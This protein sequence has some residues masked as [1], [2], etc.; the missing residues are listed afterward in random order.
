MP[1]FRMHVAEKYCRRIFSKTTKGMFAC[2]SDSPRIFFWTHVIVYLNSATTYLPIFLQ[3]QLTPHQQR[4][5][6]QN[7][8]R[9]AFKRYVHFVTLFSFIFKPLSHTLIGNVLNFGPFLHTTTPSPRLKFLNLF[10]A[11][12][13]MG[14]GV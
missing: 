5:K 1:F 13:I 3:E 14:T 10:A 8:Y 12:T 4:L 2:N 7:Q 6:K 11:T 9:A